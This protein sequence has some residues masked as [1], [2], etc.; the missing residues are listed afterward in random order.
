MLEKY[1]RAVPRVSGFFIACTFINDTACTVISG[2][3]RITR[4]FTCTAVVQLLTTA[5]PP[6]H[7]FLSSLCPPTKWRTELLTFFKVCSFKIPPL[8]MFSLKKVLN[9]AMKWSLHVKLMALVSIWEGYYCLLQSMVFVLWELCFHTLISSQIN[10][11]N[12]SI[13]LLS[14]TSNIPINHHLLFTDWIWTHYWYWF[15]SQTSSLEAQCLIFVLAIIAIIVIRAIIVI[16]YVS[17]LKSQF[18]I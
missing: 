11:C 14:N 8:W 7:L 2:I 17:S 10:H 12:V 15:L 6:P 1:W 13:V 5:N 4:R 3:D 18:D 9:F 16:L